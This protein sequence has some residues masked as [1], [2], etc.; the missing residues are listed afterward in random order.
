MILVTGATGFVGKKIM[1]LC[2]NTVAAPSLRNV[3]EDD[4]RRILDESGADVIVHTAAISDI[5]DCEADPEG[6]YR[7]N[8]ELPVFLAK[9]A[10]GRK[11]VCF[12]SDQVYTGSEKEGPYIEDDAKPANTYAKQKLEME[13]RVLD[14]CPDAV[15]LRA[16]WMYDFGPGKP[17][18]YTIVQNAT[19]PLR[20]SSRNY[21][22]VTYVK[23][24]AENMEKV[25]DL[26]GGAYNFG[27]ET[28]KSMYDVT[29]EFAGAL[30][31]DIKLED[32]QPLHN[33]WMD[34]SKARKYG[35]VFSEVLDG[36]LK[37]AKDEG[38]LL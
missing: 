28:K 24:V 21:R 1:D 29:R 9:A 19:D 35:V 33:L 6:S 10:E 31:L 5:Q 4:V 38:G 7:A 22:G 16:E 30:G 20:F 34:C 15:M 2:K 8:V 14:I 36:L 11:L 27:S 13:E 12:S 26:P 23:E 25:I 18:Y 17:N 32:V 37:C 3:T